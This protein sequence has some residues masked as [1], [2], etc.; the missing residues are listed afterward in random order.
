MWFDIT[1]LVLFGF[2]VFG[3]FGYGGFVTYKREVTGNHFES[4]FIFYSF[5]ILAVTYT[6][7]TILYLGGV[8][9]WF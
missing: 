5:L 9:G 8:F 4:D 3:V 6:T 7:L 1:L 2:V